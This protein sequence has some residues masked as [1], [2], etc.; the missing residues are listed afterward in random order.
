VNFLFPLFIAASLVIGIPILIHLFNFRKYKKVL[1]PDIRFLKELQEQTQ[2]SSRL[3]H[4]LILASR[5]LAILSL[6]FA[7]AQPFFSKD[8]EKVTQGPKA[9]SIYVDNSFSMGVEKNAISLVDLAKGKAKEIIETYSSSDQFQILTNDFAYNENRFL[10]KDE[11]LRFLSTI[12]VSA[13][14]RKAEII[15][16]KQKQLLQTENGFKKQIVFISDFQK[17]NFKDNVVVDDATQKFFV[18]VNANT[19]NNIT[20]DTLYFE[21]PTILLNEP[22]N[23]V[24]KLKNNSNEEANTA[25]TLMEHN[26]LKSVVNVTL[27]AN[28]L[29]TQNVTFTTAKAGYQNLKIFIQ[30]NPIRFDDT[31]FVAGKVSSN[32]SVLVLNQSNANAFLSSVFKPNVQFKMDNNNVNSFNP[33]LLSNYSLV[34]LNSVTALSDPLSDALIQFAQKGGSILVFA[35]QNNNTSGINS[36]LTKI[37]GCSY[38]NFDTN[39]LFVTSFNKSHAIFKDIFVKTPENIELPMVYKHFMLSKAAL[40]SE[41]KLFTYSN[42]DAYLSSYK[43]GAGILY[44]CGSSAEIS[45]SNFPKSYWFLPIIYKMAFMNANNSINAFTLG[46]NASFTVENNKVSDKTIYHVSGNGMDA[47]PEQRSIGSKIQLNI[48]QGI[49]EAGLYSVYLEG[50]KDSNFVGINYNRA[51]SVMD[52]WTMQELK[53]NS[54]IKNAEW[55]EDNINASSSINELQHGIPLWKVCIF[56]ALLFLLIEILL[57]RLM[58]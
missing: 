15:L 39:K 29:K 56:L 41:Q 33:S 1:F 49:K 31:F 26:Q 25:L 13:T 24:V 38:S 46:K 53:N 18:S 8:K 19:I 35:P 17:N 55:L 57:I 40:S 54:K 32:Y 20:L 47:I 45:A 42:G 58:K 11:A 7:F 34:V 21:S 44:V 22:N 23:I 9:V 48:N 27:K 10:T 3:K 52:F 4:L 2:K 51:E 37:A 50:S 14:S 5:I 36:F 30:D 28:E 43:I 6:V 16:E 12:Q